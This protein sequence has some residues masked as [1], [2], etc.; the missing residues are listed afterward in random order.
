M[1]SPRKIMIITPK[2]YQVIINLKNCFLIFLKSNLINYCQE[3]SL[4]M[5]SKFLNYC[6]QFKTDSVE[7]AN[8]QFQPG[9]ID[10]GWKL[11]VPD[12]KITDFWDKY[13][14]YKVKPGDQS[15]LLERPGKEFNVLKIDLDLK[16]LASQDDLQNSKP[17]HKYT[18]DLL[19]D[20]ISLYAQSATKFIELPNL[21][22][23][24]IFEKQNGK[25]KGQEKDSNGY[26]KDGVHIMC[27]EIIAPNTILH[28]IYDCFIKMPELAKLYEKFHNVE[29]VDVMFDSKVISTNAWFPIGSGKPEDNKDYYAPTKTY[30]VIVKSQ[31][32]GTDTKIQLKEEKLTL[33]LREQISHFSNLGKT[34]N[35]TIKSSVN[36]DQLVAQLGSKMGNKKPGT[37]TAIDK[38]NLQKLVI[39]KLYN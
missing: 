20:V 31:T 16:H 35:V 25:L 39:A 27:P 26:V 21:C 33:S 12:D 23:F 10:K 32:A 5:T 9:G 15:H 4:T 38:F 3:Q 30:K 36:I 18:H 6:S 14:E 8:F 22:M 29:P 7:K 11:T 24:T 37:L 17:N 13:Y 34:C 19:K 28:A 1:T 2:K